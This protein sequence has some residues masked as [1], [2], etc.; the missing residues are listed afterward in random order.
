MARKVVIAID[1]NQDGDWNR[2]MPEAR[3]QLRRGAQLHLAHVIPLDEAIGPL[4][5]FVPTEVAEAHRAQMHAALQECRKDL[6]AGSDI[7]F[8]L[9]TGNIYIELLRLVRTIN[10]ALIIVGASGQGDTGFKLGPNA[11]RMVRHAAVSVLVVRD[12]ALP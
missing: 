6:P 3:E 7:R 2:L 9:A 11:A 8:H 4:S 5:Q 10:P 1:L 12:M